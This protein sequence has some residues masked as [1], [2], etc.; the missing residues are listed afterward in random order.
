MHK[1][2]LT[3]SPRYSWYSTGYGE[4]VG[5]RGEQL[6]PLI[7]RRCILQS[8]AAAGGLACGANVSVSAD[9]VKRWKKGVVATV[10]PLATAAGVDAFRRGGNA[11]D[12]AIAAAVTLGVVDQHNSG[13]GGGCFILIRQADGKFL[14]IDGREMAPAKASHDMYLREGKPQPELSQTGPLAVATPGALAAYALALKQAG[15]LNLSAI[16]S[17]AADLAAR[18][19]PLDR[20]YARKLKSTV[21]KLKQFPGS[22]TALLKSDGL[23]YAEG[24]TL[25]QP[26]L[27]NT[28]RLIAERGTDWFYR[29]EFA[30]KIGHWMKENGGLLTAADFAAYKPIVREPLQSAYR[31]W[32]IIGFPPPSSGGVHVAQM[33]NML[34]QFD[35]AELSKKEDGS[36]EH[37]LAEVMKLAFAD[38][39]HWL[40][41]SD[42]AKVPRGLIAKDYAR[43]L[44]AKIDLKK[45]SDVASHGRPPRATENIFSLTTD[46][47]AG[48]G[49]HTTHIAA[50]DA[51]GNWV[52]ITAT[53]NTTFGS[54]VIVPGTGLVL[55]NEMDD[56]S[57]SPGQPNAF[58][59]IGAE[60]NAVQPGKRPLSSMSPTIVLRDGQ[61][62]LSVG[63]AGG[64]TIITQVLQ[65]LVRVLDLQQPLHA[66]V[67]APR[68][69]QQW[70]PDELRVEKSLPQNALAGLE[71]RGHKLDA[72]A[73]IGICQAVAIDAATK[74]LIG[75]H[76]P[77]VPGAADG[78]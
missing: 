6:Q 69:H 12:A 21:E 78:L 19:F 71:A 32:Q 28:Y 74:E 44:A 54:K 36:L 76:D 4:R 42:F 33:L 52:A 60:A 62:L 17:P 41:D 68:V 31:H 26:D 56:F 2:R 11:V 39:A 34:E 57:I 9:N 75:V 40:G 38:R 64:P 43:A 48:G 23:P 58:G 65:V 10:Q 77:R 20:N 15:K 22:A 70:R 61:P 24:E 55:N 18:G 16:M 47:A 53:V 66:A 46:P 29:G 25:K 63:A 3:P 7:S 51:E 49:K 1:S 59:L 37:L 72:S 13:L 5:V 35:L 67:A 50:A 45:A 27:A 8:L 14:A 73:G 30:T